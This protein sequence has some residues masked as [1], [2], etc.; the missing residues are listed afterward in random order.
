MRVDSNRSNNII[1]QQHKA[2]L[3]RSF[4]RQ[5]SRQEED[6]NPTNTEPTSILLPHRHG[7]V[8]IIPF[9]DGPPDERLA[10][11]TTSR[12]GTTTTFH[13]RNTTNATAAAVGE[14]KHSRIPLPVPHSSTTTTSTTQHSLGHSYPL[15]RKDAK[16]RK[17]GR[18]GFVART[19]HTERHV[20]A[21]TRRNESTTTTRKI[22]A[23][24]SKNLAQRMVEQSGKVVACCT[25]PVRDLIADH[26]DDDSDYDD[27]GIRM[28]EHSRFNYN[29]QNSMQKSTG[30]R[31]APRPV[32]QVLYRPKTER[33]EIQRLFFDQDEIMTLE[34]EREDTERDQYELTADD[35]NVQVSFR[36]R[37]SDV[38]AYI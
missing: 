13:H 19:P 4:R 17:E 20:R 36:R 24:A 5:Q 30:V 8:Q 32:T 1:L 12:H 27:D 6:T 26:D 11:S 25:G 2:S 15:F 31:F 35:V 28:D 10:T 18:F 38:S 37:T 16:K 14:T 29:Y 7:H 33:H 22:P 21:N 34:C 9:D 3:E 23:V